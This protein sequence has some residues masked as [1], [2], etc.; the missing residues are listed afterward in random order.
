MQAGSDAATTPRHTTS[1]YERNA[2]PAVLYLQG[3]KAGESDAQGIVILDFGRPAYLDGSDGTWTYNSSFI[4]FA[5]ITTAVESY[6]SAYYR[7]APILQ[8]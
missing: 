8:D 7:Y 5:S 2:N 6:A 4:S 1:Y 3:E